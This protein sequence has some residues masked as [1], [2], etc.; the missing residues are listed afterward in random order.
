MGISN[1][2]TSER[3][4]ISFSLGIIL[5]ILVIVASGVYYFGQKN[6]K[7]SPDKTTAPAAFSKYINDYFKY[8]FNYPSSE[9]LYKCPDETCTSIER[10]SLRVEVLLP[11]DF[12][13]DDAETSL[14]ADDLFCSADGPGM[15]ISCKNTSVESITN[16]LGV[17]GFRVLR[18]KTITGTKAIYPTGTYQ[19]VVYV[20]PFPEIKKGP[21]ES[22]YTAIMF[23][24]D[25]PTQENLSE[26][27]KI[28]DSFLIK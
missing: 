19:D 12:S 9:S 20:Y 10:I 27:Q 6:V 15:S 28:A 14:M 26:L 25:N 17:E 3:G 8:S 21:G 4:A 2:V 5:A 24:V 7:P 22:N 11:V 13:S 16:E 1:A 18:T 23:A